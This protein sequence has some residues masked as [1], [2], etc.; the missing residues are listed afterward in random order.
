LSNCWYVIAWDH[1]LT[2]G[3]LISRRVMDEAIVLFRRPDGSVAALEDRCVHRLAPLS[4]GRIEA[5]SV[6]C[7]YHG[8]RFAADGRCIEIPGHTQQIPDKAC[9]RS[10]PVVEAHSWIWVWMGDPEVADQALIP[11][12]VGLRDE[13][14]VLKGGYLDYAANHALINENLTDLSHLSYVH[15]SS[16]GA[17]LKWAETRPKVEALERG[18]RVSR[19][20]QGSPPIPPLGDAAGHAEVDIWSTYDFLAPGVF[21]MFTGLYVA[22]TAER[23]HGS[24]P[25]EGFASLHSNFTS[26]AVTPTSPNTSRYFFGWGPARSQGD[27][28]MAQQMLDI[29]L[30]AFN[31]DKTIIEAQQ[32]VMDLDR[33]RIPMPL[34]A[35]RGPILY[36][37]ILKRLIEQERMV[38]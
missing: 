24:A 17:D 8:L 38:G 15:A 35:D 19:W 20:I 22:G 27:E 28:A 13:R 4:L 6:R 18:V 34:P 16:F 1:E 9:V 31:E 23:L 36:Q 21:L 37:R 11:K 10:F 7:L 30:Q 5:D 2:P 33:T 12:A 14:F 32:R 3:N 26:Q 29:A 25:P